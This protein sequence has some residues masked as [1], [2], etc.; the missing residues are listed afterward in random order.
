[1]N[2]ATLASRAELVS[3]KIEQFLSSTT[4]PTP[5]VV[6]DL[7]VV[8]ERYRGLREAVPEADVYYAVKANPGRPILEQLH[9]LGSSFDVASPAEIDA[10]LAVGV[11]GQRISY[12]NTIKKR[13]DIA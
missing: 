2:V 6:V 13:R 10:C 4:A 12:G 11:P 3:P 1:M 8:D 9:A 5:F 7:D